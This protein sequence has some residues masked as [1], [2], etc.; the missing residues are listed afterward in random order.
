MP[1]T[2]LEPVIPVIK[3]LQTYVLDRTATGISE[4]IL[5]RITT[6]EQFHFP[7]NFTFKIRE[8]KE[9]FR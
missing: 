8:N 7:V 9:K 1:S 5:L 3:R 4:C 2:G 6:D